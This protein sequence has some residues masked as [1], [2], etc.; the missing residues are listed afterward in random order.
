MPLPFPSHRGDFMEA[1]P[2]TKVNQEGGGLSRLNQ[3]LQLISAVSARLGAVAGDPRG[4]QYEQRREG[5]TRQSLLDKQSA[6][7][8]AAMLE[9]AQG[10]FGLEEKRFERQEG[11]DRLKKPGR[12]FTGARGGLWEEPAGGGMAAPKMRQALPAEVSGVA[13]G[14]LGPELPPEM[15]AAIGREGVQMRQYQ[16]PTT[17]A[18]DTSLSELELWVQQNPGRPISEFW[19]QQA[20]YEPTGKPSALQEKMNLFLSNPQMYEAMYGRQDAASMIRLMEGAQA[21]ALAEAKVK[22]PV[23]PMTAMMDPEKAATDA[24]A[25]EK[26][27]EERTQYYMQQRL[28]AKARVTGGV[29][30]P[31]PT[32]APSTVPLYD[33]NGN[34]VNQ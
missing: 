22:Y 4:L 13:P 12:V 34:P 5:E 31:S 25:R 27:I 20:K 24:E 19:Q 14:T 23:D 26:F 10:R 2:M 32:P 30:A 17:P 1:D 21:D 33:M 11:L 8:R 3:I 6:E 15:Q 9:L 29:A 16:K 18:T 28:D 7:H